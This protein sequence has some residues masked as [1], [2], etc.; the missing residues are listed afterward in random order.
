M[1]LAQ[2]VQDIIQAGR[3]LFTA[4]RLLILLVRSRASESG[5]NR[6]VVRTIVILTFVLSAP[7]L[8]VAISNLGCAW[9]AGASMGQP[10]V[11]ARTKSGH[12]AC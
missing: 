12:K 11:L 3:S 7:W 6:C 10:A 5:I 8:P 4:F 1:D 9:V 2:S